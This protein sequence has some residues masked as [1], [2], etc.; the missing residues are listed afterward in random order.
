MSSS[1]VSFLA[2]SRGF[3]GS[4]AVKMFVWSEKPITPLRDSLDKLFDERRESTP[5][6]RVK[7]LEEPWYLELDVN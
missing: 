1:R 3:A 4:G 6:V 7:H 5:N 2:E